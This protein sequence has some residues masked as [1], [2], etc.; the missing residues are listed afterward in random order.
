V[1]ASLSPSQA[2]NIVPATAT[3]R[4]TSERERID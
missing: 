2:V 4:A 1:R 3:A